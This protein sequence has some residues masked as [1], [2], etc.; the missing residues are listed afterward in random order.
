MNATAG[1]DD[2]NLRE[3]VDELQARLEHLEALLLGDVAEPETPREPTA[4]EVDP[5]RDHVFSAVPTP[6]EAEQRS[7]RRLQAEATADIPLSTPA[8]RPEPARPAIDI[9]DIEER[10]AGRAL[11]LVGGAALLL[12]AAFFLSLAFSRGWI[13]PSMQVAL[14]LIGGSL[15]LLS[16][17]VLLFRGERIVG[18]VL[19]AV[20]LAVISL[21]LFAATS[22]YELIEPS[23]ALLGVFAAAL[24]IT[25]IAIRSGSQVAAG[26]GLAAVLAAPPIMGAQPDLIT[27][28][29]M[30]VVLVG[31]AAISLWQTWSW[32]PP[33]AFA[34]SVP[35][36]YQ[37]IATEPELAL[38]VPAILG[39]WTVMAVA[40]GGEAF[41]GARRELSITSAPLFL[42]V[43]A[44][45]IGLGFILL[46]SDEQ[47]AALL[48]LLAAMHGLVTAFFA[49][50]RG[51]L[52][53]FGLLAGAY[54]GAMA[55]AAV[56]LLLD[57][58]ATTVVWAAEAAALAFFAGRRGHGPAL[59]ASITAFT[60]A[61]AQLAYEALLLGPV[62]ELA[63]MGTAAGSVWG[64]IV[65][66]AFLAAT[67]VAS[68]VFVP[69]SS[70][71]LIVVGTVGL[72]ALPLTYLVFDGAAAVAVWMVTA[73]ISLGAP[74]GVTFLPERRIRW[75]LGPALRWLRPTGETARNASLLPT[76]TGAVAA[77]LAI[78]GTTVAVVDQSRLPSVPFTDQAG[79]CALALAGGFVA[80][81]IVLGGATSLRR[82]LFAAGL[83]IGMVSITELAAPWYVLVWAA[84]AAGAAWMSLFDDRGIVSYRH[85]AL[86]AL[87]VLA[88][89][90]IVEA[91]PTR[92]MVDVGGVPPHPLLL[93][94]A[95][96]ALGTLTMA[97]MA[98]AA[99]A[100]APGRLVAGLG[101]IAGAAALYLLS[102]GTVDIFAG[103]AYGLGYRD[104]DRID[105][106]AKEAQVALSI[107]WTAVGVFVLG[108]GLLLRRANL[109]I[110]GL[111]VLALSTVKVFLFDLSALDVAY[112]VITL[113]VLGLLLIASAYAWNRMKPGH[114]AESE[115]EGGGPVPTSHDAHARP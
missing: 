44:A 78:A 7:L 19:T 53:P 42:A 69:L 114:A 52:D 60:I 99:I 80:I 67:G 58:P 8:A 84:L 13:G 76:W 10:L 83:T 115:G 54:G 108:L 92:L 15:G 107:L 64:A 41:R 112:R 89:L 66:F 90:A 106:L 39:Y 21:S 28:A 49:R 27:V 113:L 102:V 101:A 109:R 34:L 94:E 30:A 97:I 33:L 26:F 17:A 110:A 25:V 1:T 11:A 111:V 68:M 43:G 104:W 36:L 35:Q 87:S 4:P 2:R 98:V 77:G 71:R 48:F 63:V 56:P 82:C 46:E 3:R 50:R 12:G 93:S 72:V 9:R 100:R 31:I 103:E 74:R 29:Y 57:A 40:A 79:L 22:L 14:G 61:S 70:F 23:S 16:G 96:L 81:G 20:G 59:I 24:V 95:T 91:P 6:P 88:A 45:V 55:T 37:W 18:H 32:L 5:W 65:A 73:V 62:A 86:G 47:R 105:E 51:L 75:R 85:M 38:G